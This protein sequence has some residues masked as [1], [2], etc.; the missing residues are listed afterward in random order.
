MKSL[1]R[2]LL[3]ITLISATMGEV[4]VYANSTAQKQKIELLIDKEIKMLEG[5]KSYGATLQFRLIELYAEKIKLVQ[6]KENSA[7][8]SSKITF[9][10][11]IKEEY[12]KQTTTL[13][14][15]M[16]RMAKDLETKYP[17]F[18]QQ[19]TMFYIMAINSRDF[20]Q[21]RETESY[22]IKALNDKKLVESIKHKTHVALA[23][24]YYNEKK[25]PQAINH[26]QKVVTNT[27]DQWLT[28]HL[29]NMAWCQFKAKE[30][31]TAISTLELS[32]KL[33][34][35]RKYLSVEDQ[36][37]D[38]ISIFHTN[39]GKVEQ[40]IDFYNTNAK[41]PW[42]ELIKLAE[43]AAKKGNR[44]GAN[45]AISSAIKSKG[46][47]Q[48]ALLDIHRRSLYLQREFA[49]QERYFYHM[50]ELEK[51]FIASKQSTDLTSEIFEEIR[52][53]TGFMQE[54]FLK[55]W[56]GQ[57][58][59]IVTPQR[60][61]IIDHFEV[62]KNIDPKRKGEMFFYQ[63]ETYYA[64]DDYLKAANY[65]IAGIRWEGQSTKDLNILQKMLDSLLASID[66]ANLKTQDLQN[67]LVFTYE[68]YITYF[69]IHQTTQVIYPKLANL[70]LT[71]NNPSGAEKLLETYRRH[72]PNDQEQQRQTASA[73]IDHHIKKHQNYQVAKWVER[74]RTGDFNFSPDYIEKAQVILANMIFIDIKKDEASSSAEETAKKYESVYG[75]RYYPNR[76]KEEAAFNLAI[77][78]LKY[79]DVKNSLQWLKASNVLRSEEK[80]LNLLDQIKVMAMHYLLL[81]ATEQAAET[82]EYILNKECAHS[83]KTPQKSFIQLMYL[84]TANK[85]YK[86]ILKLHQ[87]YK[88]CINDKEKLL[89]TLEDL[90]EEIFIATPDLASTIA[91]EYQFASTKLELS[92]L[93]KRFWE[94][95]AIKNHSSAEKLLKRINTYVHKDL[96]KEDKIRIEQLN[97]W[98]AW[99]KK[100]NTLFDAHTLKIQKILN[101]NEVNQDQ[102]NQHLE[103]LLSQLA[104]AESEL[105]IHLLANDQNIAIYSSAQLIKLRIH[106]ANELLALNAQSTSA[107]FNSSFKAA[108]SDLAKKLKQKSLKLKDKTIDSLRRT[109]V[110]SHCAINLQQDIPI[111]MCEPINYL[112]LFSIDM[113][114]PR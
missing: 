55:Q 108:M 46:T 47:N 110:L 49:D 104:S 7:L 82:Q 32:F 3:I 54:R 51:I 39:G 25:Y 56:K 78:H 6:E 37:L 91:Q 81:Q 90:F 62:L 26:Y 68:N 61:R 14:N 64:I 63:G 29:Y 28:K 48:Q 105:E 4:N 79:Q 20:D 41:I 95:L 2:L 75:D 65:Y 70:Y 18:P 57:N 83:L 53:Y 30:I 23:E 36:V 60:D 11:K 80:T 92:I 43:R 59:N 35:D 33:S 89:S 22:L 8:L 12:F 96:G 42:P 93:F 16:R 88:N 99:S 52:S 72:Y 69:P 34:Q 1:I 71:K 112:K 106:Y 107:E 19:S 101:M 87:Q 94:E 17:N 15:K 109:K 84:Y 103:S 76:I 9:H 113:V 38:A 13:Y 27:S 31:I 77:H 86:K 10:Q 45:L 98:H 50:K 66:R 24:H 40:A 74:L 85:E 21:S 114:K 102:L 67:Y 100:S 44:E 5:L 97:Q 111:A 58:H 73:I